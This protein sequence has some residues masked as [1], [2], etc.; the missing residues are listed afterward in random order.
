[1]N[2]S[3]SSYSLSSFNSSPLNSSNSSCSNALSSSSLPLSSSSSSLCQRQSS[4]FNSFSSDSSLNFNNNSS[5]NK[6]C[7]DHCSKHYSY[8]YWDAKQDRDEEEERDHQQQYWFQ[9]EEQCLPLCSP[10]QC[11]ATKPLFTTKCKRRGG[12]TKPIIIGSRIKEAN[13]GF[14]GSTD[15]SRTMCFMQGS[16][17]VVV[18]V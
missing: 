18:V 2:S 10:L 14:R 11:F 12:A 5:F 1:M 3:S 7:F 4:L 17:P 13:A 8:S 9:P 16:K 15:G 6:Q